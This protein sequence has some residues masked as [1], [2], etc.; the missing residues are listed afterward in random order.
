MSETNNKFILPKNIGE[1]RT[2]IQ[3]IP[4]NYTVSFLIPVR[5]LVNLCSVPLYVIEQEETCEVFI[6][7]QNEGYYTCSSSNQGIR[8]SI[9]YFLPLEELFKKT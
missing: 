9:N 3:D 2:L 1:L 5:S 4:D 8:Q 6:Q 7:C